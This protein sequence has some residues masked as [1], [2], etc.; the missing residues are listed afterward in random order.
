M[1]RITSNGS[2]TISLGLIFLQ[3]HW[4]SRLVIKM[5]VHILTVSTPANTTSIATPT[6]SSGVSSFLVSKYVNSETTVC[7]CEGENKIN[8]LISVN[9]FQERN[10]ERG[11]SWV[12]ITISVPK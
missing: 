11:V 3:Y 6:T 8:N 7:K 5:S 4:P 1:E 12:H 2:T 9:L 10:A